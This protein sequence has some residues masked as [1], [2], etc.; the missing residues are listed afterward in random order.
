MSPDSSKPRSPSESEIHTYITDYAR[1]AK[2]T[3]A[4]GVDAVEIHA[5]NGFLIDQFTQDMCNR[6]TDKWGGSVENRSRLAVGVT[7]T[8]VDAV[9]PERRGIWLSPWSKFQG[10]RMTDVI[11]Q[12]RHR[13]RQLSKFRLAYILLL[14]SR[15][16]GAG[17][18][19]ASDQLDS[20]L[21]AFGKGSAVIVTGGY[22]PDRIEEAHD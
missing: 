16:S 12:F 13:A 21:K 18:A 4:A 17:D 9:G 22:T 8:A 19:E 3:I 11:P 10:I 7:K 6:H 15:V 1:A 2:N 5:A 14:E 20:L